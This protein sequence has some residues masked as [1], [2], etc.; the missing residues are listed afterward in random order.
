MRDDT[1]CFSLPCDVYGRL[2]LLCIHFWLK[3][4]IVFSPIRIRL[5]CTRNLRSGPL[6]VSLEKRLPPHESDEIGLE[7]A[8]LQI[9]LKGGISFLNLWLDLLS[10]ERMKADLAPDRNALQTIEKI[11]V[12]HSVGESLHKPQIIE[13]R[14]IVSRSRSRNQKRRILRSSENNNSVTF[15]QV[16]TKFSKSQAEAEEP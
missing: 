11:F 6:F 12:F 3:G 2:R 10:C 15:N 16:K 13:I 9:Y 14:Q 4:D 8:I 7:K 5:P 1:P